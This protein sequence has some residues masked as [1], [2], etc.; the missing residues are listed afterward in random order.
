MA[1]AV[2]EYAAGQSAR[3][4]IQCGFVRDG[5]A[6]CEQTVQRLQS[7]GMAFDLY[8]VG[9]RSDDTRIREWARRAQIDPMRVRDGSITLN[10]DGGRWLSLGLSG[11][12]PAVV[13]EVNGQWQRQP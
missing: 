8:M 12:L 5:C 4:G 11:E 9:S 3:R 6:A 1:T 10:H 13:R 7:S 2:P